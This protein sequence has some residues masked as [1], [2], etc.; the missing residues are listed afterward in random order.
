[1]TALVVAIAAKCDREAFARLFGYY[2]P[3]VKAYL[4]R[5]G[6]DG[7]AAEELAQEAMLIVWRRADS[8]DPAKASASTWIYTIVR[9]LRIDALR[10]GKRAVFDVN[11]PCFVQE[12]PRRPDDVMQSDQMERRV[13]EA[14]KNLP[15]EQAVVIRLSFFEDQA[16]SEIADQL[17]LPLGTVKSR[18]RLAM[19]RLQP[20]LGEA[21]D[22]DG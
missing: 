18:L 14:L 19:R 4:L 3:R 12:P 9:N 10:K 13:R 17:C 6:T 20:L 11:D 22:A 16:H 1:M 5:R 7:A 15:E 2:A 8:F 21:D